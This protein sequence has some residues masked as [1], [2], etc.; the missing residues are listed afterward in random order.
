MPAGP[1]AVHRTGSFVVHA[2][3]AVIARAVAAEAEFVR[4]ESMKRWHGAGWTVP[5]EIQVKIEE[6]PGPGGY[7]LDFPR[8]LPLVTPPRAPQIELRGSFESILTTPLPRAVT[9]AVLVSALPKLP[10][11]WAIEGFTRISDPDEEQRR[12]DAICRRLL[13]DGRAIRLEALFRMTTSTADPTVIQAQAHS[14]VRY[15]LT[16]QPNDDV[17]ADAYGPQGRSRA[18]MVQGRW[19]LWNAEDRYDSLLKFVWLGMVENTP[20]SWERAA[21]EVYGVESVAWL[22]KAWLGWIANPNKSVWKPATS[23]ATPAPGAGQGP[24]PLP[25]PTTTPTPA[26]IPA[27][28]MPGPLGEPPASEPQT[29]EHKGENFVVRGPSPEVARRVWYEAVRLRKE[30]ALLWLGKELPDWP[31]PCSIK[32]KVPP[33]ASG[34]GGATSFTYGQTVRP[35]V[36]GIT[37]AEMEIQGVLPYII[38]DVLAHEILY[39]VLATYFGK[40]VPRWADEGIAVTAESVDVRFAHDVK[41]REYLNQGRGIRLTLLFPMTEY[42]RDMHVLFAQGNSLVEFLLFS[43]SCA[44]VP[45]LSKVLPPGLPGVDPKGQT[46]KATHARLRLLA[47]VRTGMEGNTSASWNKAAKEVYGFDSVDALEAAWLDWLREPRMKTKVAPSPGRV[48]PKSD[49]S[50]LIPPTTLPATPPET[51]PNDPCVFV[52]SSRE[53]MIPIHCNPV[54]QFEIS[55]VDLYLSSDEGRTWT[56]QSTARPDQEHVKITVAKDGLY[57]VAVVIKRQDGKQEPLTL[58]GIEPAMKVRVKTEK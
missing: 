29:F 1:G 43:H 53:L 9:H 55:S 16:R 50:G 36:S 46:A 18:A 11:P 21:K 41:A 7:S 34:F 31:Q 38:H 15:L 13:A 17:G 8:D 5:C 49:T 23:E 33:G 32:V 48:T 14:V 4:G 40:P 57:W 56:R 24:I 28:A 6:K 42:P 51:D 35:R 10:P 54:E 37:S 25:P 30:L 22:Q 2:P 45:L 20:E 27:P 12:Q 19:V 47:F 39:T 44:G 52:S 58:V 26:P 3:T